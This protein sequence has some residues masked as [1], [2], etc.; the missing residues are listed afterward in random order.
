MK[1]AELVATTLALSSLKGVGPVSLKKYAHLFASFGSGGVRDNVSVFLDKFKKEFSANEVD[2]AIRQSEEI[3]ISCE[4]EGVTAIS[5]GDAAYPSLLFEIK[6]PPPVIY[7]KGNLD[8]M[9]KVVAIVGTREP[10]RSGEIIAE[11]ISNFFAG[12]NWSICNGLADG[13]DSFAIKNSAGYFNGV[14]GVLGGGIDCKNKK[15]LLKSV[16]KNADSILERNGLLVSEH[17]PNKKEDTFSIIKSCRLQA[18]LSH[19]LVLI[20]SSVDG[21]SKYTIKAFSELKRS[22]AF[23]HPL[24]KDYLLDGYGANKLLAEKDVEGLAEIIDV[25]VDKLVIDRLFS[26]K[27]KFDY[28]NYENIILNLVNN[29]NKVDLF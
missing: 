17:P 10:S 8:A 15:T 29:K 6:D 22:L 2:G 28:D 9:E 14:I 1:Y 24:Q 16:Q 18:G 27:S 3:L 12:R 25:K 26:I 21:G 13:V 11:R 7:C 19:G 5:I 20:Q 23:V 4:K